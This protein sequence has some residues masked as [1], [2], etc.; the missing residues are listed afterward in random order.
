MSEPSNALSTPWR[1][2]LL[3]LVW[4]ARVLVADLGPIPGIAVHFGLDVVLILGGWW[5]L[6]PMESK[7]GKRFGQPFT[8]TSLLTLIP[9]A[10]LVMLIRD[11]LFLV[12]SGTR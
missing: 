7:Y 9:A 8:P 6:L 3:S 2:V 11:I 10:G 4:A 12:G 5:A 1:L